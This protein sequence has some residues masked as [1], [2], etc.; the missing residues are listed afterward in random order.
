MERSA[1]QGNL[2]SHSFICVDSPLL[3]ACLR[4]DSAPPALPRGGGSG[5]AE[6]KR[7]GGEKEVEEKEKEDDDDNDEEKEEE[8]NW[9]KATM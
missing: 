2:P 9:W 3:F 4:A 5:E 1:C 8:K 7:G 6:G